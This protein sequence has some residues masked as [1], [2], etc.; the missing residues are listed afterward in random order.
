MSIRSDEKLGTERMLPL[1]FKMVV[2]IVFSVNLIGIRYYYQD[3]LA[4]CL[5]M[6]R[7]L[8]KSWELICRYSL[9]E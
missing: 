7:V 5:L 8:S 4:E 2:I 6:T 9:Q 1:V 3:L